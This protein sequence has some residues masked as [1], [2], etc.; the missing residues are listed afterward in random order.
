MHVRTHTHART[1]THTHRRVHNRAG[2]WR[3]WQPHDHA[4]GHPRPGAPV[5][6]HEPIYRGW[7]AAAHAAVLSGGG[8]RARAHALPA[9]SMRLCLKQLCPVREHEA[10][11]HH[12][13][14][15]IAFIGSH[16]IMVARKRAACKHYDAMTAL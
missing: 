1:Y 4:R 8:Q 7:L 9:G 10:R 12:A 14:I 16:S 2:H 15:M 6:P 11:K 3:A 13:S 5:P